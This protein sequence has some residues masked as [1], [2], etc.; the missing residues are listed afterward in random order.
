MYIDDLSLATLEFSPVDD[1]YPADNSLGT[2]VTLSYEHDVGVIAITEPSD[3]NQRDL[4]W[5]NYADDGTGN[6]LSSQLDLVYPFNSQVADDFQFTEA[7]DID[8]VHWWGIFWNGVSG[9]YPNP[10]EMNIIF[11]ADDGSGTMPTGAGMDDP[12]STALA[13]YN[14]PA[15]TGVSYGTDKYEYDVTIEPAF[16]AEA[17]VKYWVACQAVF[18][19]SDYGQ[20][21]WASNGANPEKLGT[22]VQGFPCLG[23][24]YWTALTY[25]DMAFQLS[26]QIHQGGGYHWPP[27]TY[28]IAGI[29]QNIGVI[30]SE[31]D[32]PVNTQ[33]TNDT[34]V[35]VYDETIFLPGLLA[36]GETTLVTFPDIIIPWTPEAEGDY[37]LTMKTMLNGD[38]HPNNDKKIL[39][40]IIQDIPDW[41][42]YTTAMLSGTMGDNDWYISCVTVTLSA[43]DGKWPTGV[44]HT[45]YKI[46]N[47][48]WIEYFE[49][50]TVC[51]DGRH[52]VYFYSEDKDIPPNVEEVKQVDFRIDKTPPNIISY[53]VTAQNQ[54]MTQWLLQLTAEDPTS[55]IVLVQFFADDV[56]IGNLTMTPYDFFAEGKIHTTQCIV[57]DEA[58]NSQMSDIVTGY[59][60]INLEQLFKIAKTSVPL[61]P[62]TCELWALHLKFY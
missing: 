26:G 37:K 30:Y 22:P 6:G 10:V 48:D 2:V 62:A 58:G 24:A 52:T 27:G 54:L 61:S 17:G 40:F 39:M 55:G 15:V 59:E 41:P 36:P 49:P 33:V 18:A 8:Q 38:D 35:I 53:T 23:T 57:Y 9:A 3:P 43:T 4:I 13:V 31:I 46:D 20:W 56:L 42:P 14:F 19:F 28:Q 12:T 45:Y 29:V 5:D 7:M 60:F 44:N 47:G 51:N 21:G 1:G 25:G 32:V 34:G 11:Y 16:V 50:F